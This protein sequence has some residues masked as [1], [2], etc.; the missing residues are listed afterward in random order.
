[1]G[2]LNFADRRV[3][4]SARRGDSEKKSGGE[5]EDDDL[6]QLE[7]HDSLSREVRK[8]G[9]HGDARQNAVDPPVEARAGM[10]ILAV[11][12]SWRPES[13]VRPVTLRP[14]LSDRFAFF[15]SFSVAQSRRG[16]KL[17]RSGFVSR[18]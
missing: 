15:S 5:R 17:E 9:T 12:L 4:G 11:P 13:L 6:I 8:A 2:A 18:G 3:G 7:F 14:C 1:M 16:S 10:L